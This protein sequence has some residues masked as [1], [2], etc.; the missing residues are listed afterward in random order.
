[1]QGILFEEF[2]DDKF[3]KKFKSLNKAIAS[4]VRN[5]GY[6]LLT[7]FSIK[8]VKFAFLVCR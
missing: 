8:D 4:M 6:L 2:E 7:L 3:S 5:M 1:M